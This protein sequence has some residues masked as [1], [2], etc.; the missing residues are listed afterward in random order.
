MSNFNCTVLYIYLSIAVFSASWSLVLRSGSSLY[1]TSRY[2]VSCGLCKG[3]GEKTLSVWVIGS[4]SMIYMCRV[5]QLMLRQLAAVFCLRA[6]GGG[7][8]TL[9]AYWHIYCSKLHQWPSLSQAMTEDMIISVTDD[10]SYGILERGKEL[11]EIRTSSLISTVRKQKCLTLV[12]AGTW[13]LHVF[14][15]LFFFFC[16]AGL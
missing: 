13:M 14:F 1:S 7:P 9:K 10:A 16:C 15:F 5:S 8:P 3:G 12:Q 2:F 4:K 6:R 11:R